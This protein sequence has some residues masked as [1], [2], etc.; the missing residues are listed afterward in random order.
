[1]RLLSLIF[2]TLLSAGTALAQSVVDN[3]AK[4]PSSSSTTSSAPPAAYGYIPFAGSSQDA[5]GMDSSNPNTPWLPVLI[6]GET[7]TPAFSGELE[8]GNQISGGMTVASGYDDNALSQNG[9]QVGNTSF[10]FL[11]TLSWQQSRPR[12]LVDFNY[13]PGFTVNQRLS[14]LNS[15][16]QDA[17]LNAQFRLTEYSTLR[18]HDAFAVTNNGWASTSSDIP[19][20]VLHQPNQSVL[21]PLTRITSNQAGADLIQRVGTGTIVG[22]SGS[23]SL[24]NYSNVQGG[25]GVQLIDTRTVGTELFYLHRFLPRHWIGVTYGFERFTFNG[26]VEDTQSHSALLFDTIT[27]QPHL[28]LSLFVGATHSHTD[29][30]V[31]IGRSSTFVPSTPTQWSPDTGAVL[32]WE[33]ER[34]SLAA[35]VSRR[36]DSGGGILGTVDRL[37]V[38]A[39]LRRQLRPH[40]SGTI[41]FGYDDNNPVD[42]AQFGYRTV[43][44]IVSVQRQIRRD[45]TI[46][47]SYARVHQSYGVV[48]PT[49]LFP[50]HNRALLSISYSF[51]RPLGR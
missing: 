50:D 7:P 37:S 20:S 32:S 24:L 29:G 9:R 4:F 15:S 6:N 39:V 26:G 11:P 51:N 33:G 22:G 8:R 5:E 30:F 41:S 49:Q 40:W 10:T 21:T 2:V 44:G 14:E 36:V 1:M 47:A 31:T 42:G 13:S 38:S 43:S 23:Y 12:S 27:I 17:G 16:T 18:I 46:A 19:G 48:I 25:P 28:T 34:N 35:T 45:L 3:S